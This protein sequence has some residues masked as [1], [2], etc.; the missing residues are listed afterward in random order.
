[1]AGFSRRKVDHCHLSSERTFLALLL[2]ACL[3][4]VTAR[5]HLV[6]VDASPAD[7]VV[8]LP[9]GPANG[10]LGRLGTTATYAG[11]Y[12]WWDKSGDTRTDLANPET[13]ADLTEFAVTADTTYL[14][15][16]ARFNDF[17]G[18]I[19]GDGAVQLQVAL[20]LDNLASSGQVWFGKNADTK[21][22][23]A[24]YWEYL[25][26][27]TFG[28]ASGAAPLHARP[29]VY[30][31]GW[32]NRASAG[33][34]AAIDGG[35]RMIEIRVPWADLGVTG[36]PTKPVRFT[37]STYRADAS[38]N[39]KP[40]GDGT[41]SNAV[42]AVTNYASDPG[43]ASN[44]WSELNDQVV[45]YYFEVWFHLTPGLDPSAPVVISEFQYDPSVEPDG[46]WVEIYNRTW[47]TITLTNFGL[48][49]EETAD[50][51]VSGE[52]MTRFPSGTIGPRSAVVVA[53]KATQLATTFGKA[54]DFEFQNSNPVPN[55]SVYTA[56]CAQAISASSPAFGNGGDELLLLD[57][58]STVLDVVT[59]ETPSVAWGVTANAGGGDSTGL[60]RS[61]P[62][63]DTDNC[64]TDFTLETQAA[65]TPG[66]VTELC[67]NG[68]TDA[69]EGC[70]E[71]ALNGQV[72]HCASDCMYTI[73]A[74][75]Y[76]LTSVI[77][78]P[79]TQVTGV[80]IVPSPATE[81]PVFTF[82]VRDHGSGDT[83]PTTVT[84]LTLSA[85]AAN[86]ANWNNVILTAT[87]YDGVTAVGSGVVSASQIA[88]TGLSVTVADG[89]AKD[90]TLRIT[91]KATGAIVDGSVLAF[92]VNSN[93]D[94]TASPAGSVFSTSSASDVNSQLF[95]LDVQG[96]RL[97]VVS[98]STTATTAAPFSLSIGAKDANGNVDTGFSGPVGLTL[99]SGTGTLSAPSGLSKLASGTAAWADLRYNQGGSITITAASAGLTSVT[100]ASIAVTLVVDPDS[101]AQAPA[102]PIPGSS[103][104]ATSTSETSVFAFV[105]R[106]KGT[107][108][109]LP[110]TTAS[111]TIKPAA[112]NTALWANSLS[113][114]RLYQGG[115]QVGGDGVITNASIVF[116]GL[117][118]A[119]ADGTSPE[120][121]LRVV[122]K[123]TG[124]AVVDGS[125]LA[126]KLNSNTDVTAS[127]GG[128][129]YATSGA[130]DVVS[131]SF[132]FNVAGTALYVVSQP[133]NV[134]PNTN[135]T[136]SFGSRDANGNQDLDFNQAVSLAV[137]TGAGTLSSAGDPDLSKGAITGAA[138]WADLHYSTAD[139]FTVRASATGM[140]AATTTAITCSLTQDLSGWKLKQYNSS[141]TYTFAA[142]TSVTVGG[143][144]IVARNAT[145]TQ[146][147]TTWG[148]TLNSN[149]TYLNSGGTI[150]QL[151]GGET[152]EL[153]DASNVTRDGITG[154]AD[155]TGK[156]C[157]RNDTTGMG[158]TAGEWTCAVM[159]G[160]TPGSGMSVSESGRLVISEFSDASDFNYEFVELFFDAGAG[161]VCGN[162]TLE[163]GEDCDDGRDGDDADGC[164]DTCRFTCA[165][166]AT[167]CT[168][169]TAGDCTYP[170]CVANSDGQVCESGS[171]SGKRPAPTPCTVPGEGICDADGVCQPSPV[172]GEVFISEINVNPAVG[173]GGEPATEWVELY[174]RMGA[175]T[176]IAGWTL[177][178]KN[179]ATYAFPAGTVLPARGFLLLCH[180]GAPAAYPCD[181]FYTS[182]SFS[183][184]SGSL[185]LKD[186]L[187]A[188]KDAVTYGSVADGY[189]VQLS[190]CDLD[191]FISND[192]WCASTLAS[193][194]GTDKAT[195]KAFGTACAGDACTATCGN[196]VVEKGEQCDDGKN[197]N[198]ADGCRDTCLYSCDA[199]ARDC[200]ADP[201]GDCHA[202]VCADAPNG[203]A[204]S[205]VVNDADLPADEPNPC[206]TE[207]CS[208]GTP[209]HPLAADGTDCGNAPDKWCVGGGCVANVCGDGFVGDAELCEGADGCSNCAP[210][211]TADSQ[212]PDAAPFDTDCHFP[213][214]ASV[215]S[216]G[217]K[218][219]QA[220][221]G[222]GNLP[223]GTACSPPAGGAC[224]SNG[225][226]V[227]PTAEGAIIITE[228]MFDPDRDGS[229]N[230]STC[231][232]DSDGEW[233]EVSNR[234]DSPIDLGGWS[235]SDAAPTT[236]TI[237]ASLIIPPGGY[238]VLCRGTGGGQSFCNYAWG[239]NPS[240]NN[241]GAESIIFKDPTGHVVDRVDFMADASWAGDTGIS[242]ML[243]GSRM[244]AAMND[245]SW[246]WCSATVAQTMACGDYGTPGAANPPCTLAIPPFAANSSFA[247]SSPTA[248]DGDSRAIALLTVKA[249]DQSPVP[250]RS[251]QFSVSGTASIVDPSGGAGVVVTDS[252]GQAV[253]YVT[254]ASA[255]SVTVTAKDLGASNKLPDQTAPLTF[256]APLATVGS[257]IVD[258]AAGHWAVSVPALP[259]QGFTQA[260]EVSATALPLNTLP[261]GT[262]LPFGAV[263]ITIKVPAPGA[264]VVLTVTAPGAIQSSQRLYLF[265]AT[266][267]DPAPHFYDVTHDLHVSGFNDGDAL[268]TIT[269]VDGGFGDADL[270]QN[271]VIVDPQAPGAN[272]ADI[273]T[274][275]EW[276]LIL[277]ALALIA[278]A[279]RRLRPNLA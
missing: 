17:G 73:A 182:L 81:T 97:Y 126:F 242:A 266:Q 264:S 129:T 219:C 238:R 131:G 145:K 213:R 155:P 72:G 224:S 76:D 113:Q 86:T 170:A 203:R 153:V 3:A 2:A 10:N 55:M 174:N 54:A 135:F 246:S 254:A 240:L 44:S 28:S 7:W 249:V 255:Q 229:G 105:L 179:N 93:T 24:A 166:P 41:I 186:A 217:G 27:T 124:G 279:V 125:V 175:A 194:C 267:D 237:N 222:T 92:K 59:Y 208:A 75:V 50:Q 96:T 189:S 212:C 275:G 68:T 51:N 110:T 257:A 23:A 271:G 13:R 171:E 98:Q 227:P 107:S 61:V 19:S 187:G 101:L 48:G 162:L 112:G 62:A 156:S 6:T 172:S 43:S 25:V 128:S 33:A 142:G 99:A 204:C 277:L 256:T 176:S 138:T 226:C 20:D 259:G 177:T 108:D 21:V 261:A 160:A 149:V 248:A 121:I 56:W 71:G 173:C 103:L 127:A 139:S 235:L 64:S 37:V 60:Y 116:S 262:S 180:T 16:K 78:A 22:A 12:V 104:A 74:P 9:A 250:G 205:V 214:C 260:L 192:T 140:S 26:V 4:P 161:S 221:A 123:A 66:V 228:F 151:N 89:A 198:D 106:D 273:P 181:L 168:D 251:F 274:L 265:G 223:G 188:Q 122:P 137:I 195:P 32:T 210:L 133:Q 132:T 35:N 230:Q 49:D 38:D 159:T 272:P 258:A 11:E 65:A 148:V 206:T 85:S 154:S 152:Y 200:P 270:T 117:G 232:G 243:D 278:L 253:V 141:Q 120:L 215:G 134:A 163:P 87:L 268:W 236:A 144:V 90:L 31:T 39:T 193:G 70:D 88:F 30:D 58:S 231:A 14:Y 111:V 191:A 207:V 158:T 202:T 8:P 45:D 46:E 109:G 42:D 94:A 143:Y 18:V 80:T 146:F 114:A 209:S 84:A 115:S 211:C 234:T 167:D 220:G 95:P 69:G 52:I 225:V 82:T 147:Q 150:P 190:L 5:A 247:V 29:I 79:G 1:M 245:Y 47:T 276:A 91:P 164:R 67:G 169:P 252:N 83:R 241:S 118:Y 263:A 269:L 216:Q 239:S 57:P 184:T 36:R 53:N 77:Q 15:F 185:T 183:N 244:S 201:A 100:S 165:T 233:V 136:L 130:T 199:P 34:D 102:S 119:V 197:G 40:I 157:V 196:S 218:A 178:D 63:R